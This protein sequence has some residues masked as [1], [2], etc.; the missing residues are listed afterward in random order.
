[1]TYGDLYQARKSPSPYP[2]FNTPRST[3][4]TSSGEQSYT[5]SRVRIVKLHMRP[6]VLKNTPPSF[7]SDPRVYCTDTGPSNWRDLMPI[8]SRVTF[9][10]C[11]SEIIP[12][13]ISRSKQQGKRETSVLHIGGGRRWLSGDAIN[14]RRIRVDDLGWTLR[15]RGRYAGEQPFEVNR[16]DLTNSRAAKVQAGEKLFH[17]DSI[18]R[19]ELKAGRR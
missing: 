8:L 14:T 1:M 10:L 3:Q 17:V 13:G 9:R 4:A 2:L 18:R 15:G 12:G 11:V 16:L 5:A 7:S 6:S 19:E